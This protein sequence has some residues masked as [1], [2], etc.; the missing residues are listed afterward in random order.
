M[1]LLHLV[2]YIWQVEI[3]HWIFLLLAQTYISRPIFSLYS[4]YKCKYHEQTSPNSIT[5][6]KPTCWCQIFNILFM[7][8]MNMWLPGEATELPLT[9]LRVYAISFSKHSGLMN[10]FFKI[11]ISSSPQD[12][13][14]IMGRKSILQKMTTHLYV[15]SLLYESRWA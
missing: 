1:W 14:K 7:L 8:E 6:V 9:W 12:C 3:S 5:C 15:I 4:V 13:R 11:S 10:S 2:S